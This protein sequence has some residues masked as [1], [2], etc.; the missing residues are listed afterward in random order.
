MKIAGANDI[1]QK[2]EMPIPYAVKQERVPSDYQ[3]GEES[4]TLAAAGS[5][6][7]P[8][9]ES[10]KPSAEG[11]L[12]LLKADKQEG[13]FSTKKEKKDDSSQDQLR[14]LKI[15]QNI[16]RGKI[17]P[18]KDEQFLI[19]HNDKLYQAAKNIASMKEQKEKVKSELEEEDDDTVLEL[20]RKLL[21]GEE[22]TA[23][24]PGAVSEPVAASP[25]AEVSPEEISE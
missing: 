9:Q 10:Y 15:A 4:L 14:A 17:V 25:S 6:D 24:A 21:S 18:Q 1:Q 20:M 3:I 22:G 8:N 19:E 13:L 7:A 2:Q 23:S 5:E 12:A 11:L 16:M